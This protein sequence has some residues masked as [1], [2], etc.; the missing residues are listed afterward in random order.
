MIVFC[1]IYERI[2]LWL[3]LDDLFATLK[4]YQGKNFYIPFALKDQN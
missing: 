3:G 2:S 1:K 4:P